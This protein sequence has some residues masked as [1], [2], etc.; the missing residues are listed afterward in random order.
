MS[1][2]VCVFL[3][4]MLDLLRVSHADARIHLN[5]DFHS[6]L[7][8]FANFLPLNNGVSL[9]DHIPNSCT[10]ELD[11]FLTGLGGRSKLG[12]HGGRVVT[13][14]PP[15]SEDGVLSPSWPQV[16]KLVVPCRWSAVYSTE[17][18]RTVCTDFLCP[19]NY[20]S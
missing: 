19:S 10:L 6:D 17:P 11:T 8:S 18:L 16:G 14:L 3:N 7:S 9:N 2:N 1:T 5:A 4:R 13:L 20:P 15:T 12:E